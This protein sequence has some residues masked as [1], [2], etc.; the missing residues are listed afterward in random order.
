MSPDRKMD[1]FTQRNI[2]QAVKIYKLNERILKIYWIKK[3]IWKE[4]IWY[5]TI[6]T[7]FKNKQTRKHTVE[8]HIHIWVEEKKKKKREQISRE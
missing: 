4:Y 3:H 2:T 1:T 7:K 5:D 6:S 8:G